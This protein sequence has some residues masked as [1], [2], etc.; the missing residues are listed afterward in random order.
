[1]A[2]TTNLGLT[3]IQGAD[4]VSPDVFNDNYDKIDAVGKVYAVEAADGTEWYYRKWSDGRC[5]AWLTKAYSDVSLNDQWGSLYETS[6]SP[7]TF[8]VAFSER[9]HMTVTFATTSGNTA[10]A[11]PNTGL[12]TTQTG[13]IL[14]C[15]SLAGQKA[16]GVLSIHAS[17]KISL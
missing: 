14:L 15:S 9:P 6:V 7:M 2:S 17:G 10:F 8:P 12:S 5:E 1:M 11:V 3:K 16:T 4:Y 13:S